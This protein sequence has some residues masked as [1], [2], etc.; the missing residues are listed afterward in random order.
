MTLRSAFIGGAALVLA[1]A[2]SAGATRPAK[3][4]AIPPAPQSSLHGR[5]A[6]STRSG[7]IWVMNA[8]GSNRHRIT[9]SGPGND[10]DPD[11]SPDGRRIVFRTSRGRYAPDPQGIG[12]EGIFVVSVRTG[13]EH[14]IQ[15]PT[16]ALFPAWSPD[17]KKIAFSALPRD[18]GSLDTIHLIDPDGSG[19]VDLG[20]PGECATWSPDSSKLMYC[21]HPGDGN[22]AVW[23]MNADGSNRRQLT[24]P[25]LMQPAGAHGDYPGA[26]SP[27]GTQIVYTSDVNGDRELFLMNADGSNQHRLTHFRGADGAAAWLPDGRIVFTHFRGGKPL[28]HWYLIRPNGNNLQSLPRFYGA[29]DPIDWRP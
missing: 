25:T 9:R 1:T 16:G 22:W 11:F 26:W 6:Y 28:P 18:G 27:D 17:G 24:H 2:C 7:D 23:V 29:G 3:S 4:S 20:A 21:S 10:F 13:R 12:L 19:L 14:Q 8:D 5:I 15:P